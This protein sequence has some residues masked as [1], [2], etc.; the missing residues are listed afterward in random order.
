MFRGCAAGPIP[1]STRSCRAAC[2]PVAPTASPSPAATCRSTSSRVRAFVGG[3]ELSWSSA[4]SR[5]MPRQRAAIVSAEVPA[6]PVAGQYD[7]TLLVD[8]R[9]ACWQTRHA[10]RRPRR[11]RADPLRQPDAEL[12]PGRRRHD[13]HDLRRRL[14]A[15][16]HGDGRPARARRRYPGAQHPRVVDRPHRDRH[17]RRPRRAQR[18]RRPGHVRQRDQPDRRR[19]LRLRPAPHRQHGRAV[20]PV[21]HLRRS[22]RPAWRSPTAAT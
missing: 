8:R 22:A 20:L 17:A 16:Q 1:R 12:G 4:S 10:R 19:R 11:R 3:V 6:L 7:V 15:R 5:A 13:G 21:R 18:R 9:T 2:S 14:P